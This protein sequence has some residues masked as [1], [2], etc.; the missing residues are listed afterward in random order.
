MEKPFPA[1]RGD[2]PYTFVCFSH[3]DADAVYYELVWLKEQGCNIWYD[4]GIAPGTEWTQELADAIEGADHFLFF[5]SPDAVDS[6]Y[7][8]DELHFAL[9]RSKYLAS[10]HLKKTLLTGGM[11]LSMGTIQSI[12]KYELSRADYRKKIRSV[13]HL[14]SPSPDLLAAR[15]DDLEFGFR[16]EDWEVAP[17]QGTLTRGEDVARLEP[18]VMG[19]LVCLARNAGEVVKRDELLEQVWPGV[20]VQEE[21]LNR[22]ISL[23]RS[24]LKDERR[25]PRFIQT[26]PRIGY[27]LVAPVRPK[28]EP[29]PKLPARPER[30]ASLAA[31]GA[32]TTVVIVLIGVYFVGQ[33]M[34]GVG[35]EWIPGGDV[36]SI[37]VLP[38][39]DLSSGDDPGNFSAGLTEEIRSDLSRVDGLRI[40]LRARN[41]DEDVCAVGKK[42]DA[43]TL[44]YISVRRDGERLRVTYQ[45]VNASDCY[46]ILSEPYEG[47]LDDIF[48]VQKAISEAIVGRLA[49]ALGKTLDVLQPTG[50][51]PQPEAY[52]AFLLGLG[53]SHLA[54]R[55]EESIRSSIELFQDAIERDPDLAEA[56][57]NLAEAYTLL[58]TYLN[59][60][61]AQSYRE[62]ML[63]SARAHLARVAELDGNSN[64]TYA[65]KAFI[66]TLNTE[67]T[68]AEELF[69]QAIRAQPNDA[70]LHYWY[71]QFLARVGYTD[72]SVEEAKLA[73]DLDDVAPLIKHRVGIS[74]LWSGLTDLAEEQFDIARAAGLAPAVLAKPDLI[75]LNRQKKFEELTRLF[76]AIQVQRG[77]STALITPLIEALKRPDDEQSKR[78]GAAL[79][80]A[81]EAGELDP[82]LAWGAAIMLRQP[83]LVFEITEDLIQNQE[84]SDLMEFLFAEEAAVCRASPLFSDFVKRVQLDL[85]WDQ[86]GWPEACERIDGVISCH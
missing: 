73:L 56:H 26:V 42:L 31:L 44:L 58:P 32:A 11:E 68:A 5:V 53:Q 85:F 67:W 72:R 75:L 77:R 59:E 36:V 37:A 40:M 65:T 54:H 46:L 82:Q 45:W 8:R 7:C 78:V 33:A 10:V 76:S 19:V 15:P 9:S 80:Q 51:P 12:L 49:S 1:Y 81:V 28:M 84:I 62:L 24:S 22:S 13:L 39:V 66:H 21:V 70:D 6:K 43:D 30:V 47:R 41:P 29:E 61:M 4:E 14:D 35:P 60:V 79:L 71:S 3:A 2:D 55:G 38:V 48:K 57:L 25:E 74:Y 16:V 64:R 27:R 86:N 20:V 69:R 34:K 23:L 83:Q 17:R 50:P 18:K 52:Q 63:N